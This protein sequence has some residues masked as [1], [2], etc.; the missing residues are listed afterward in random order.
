[1]TFLAWLAIA[2]VLLIIEIATPGLFFFACLGVGAFLAGLAAWLGAA[3]WLQW[4]V[5]FGSS[6][7]LVVTVAP[8]AR[9]FLKRHSHTPVGLDS[10]KGQ[11]AYVLQAISPTTGQGQV[12]LGNGAIWLALS[13]VEV[14]QDQWVE[15]LEIR[16][17]RLFVHPVQP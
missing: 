8:L 16:G 7:L 11:R 9:R 15:V 6:L 1:M 17:T 12:R 14:P 3:M 2:A 4:T 13:D 5:F 10:L